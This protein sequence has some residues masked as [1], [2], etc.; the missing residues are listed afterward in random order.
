MHG[1]IDAAIIQFFGLPLM[2][3]L[4]NLWLGFGT[5]T[6][7]LVLSCVA[8]LMRVQSIEMRVG[9]LAEVAR[10]RAAVAEK[11][12]THVLGYSLAFRVY[13]Q[14]KDPE[15]RDEATREATVVDDCARQYGSFARTDREREMAT[16]IAAMWQELRATGRPL[17]ETGYMSLEEVQ[18]CYD[19]RTALVEFLDGEIQVD[20]L[21]TYN[22]RREA[23]LR[24]VNSIQ[25]LLWLL[26]VLGGGIT[27]ASSLAF[28]RAILRSEAAARADREL[29]RVTLASIG[30]AVITTDTEGRAAYLNG[31]AEDLTGWTQ[32][33]AA[34]QPLEQVF[35]IVD[36]STRKPAE[37]PAARAL[38]EGA[39]VGL[40][41]H[42]VLIA[43]DGVERAIDDSAAPIRDERG[44]VS[45]VVLVFRD[46]AQRRRAELLIQEAVEQFSRLLEKL[47]VA[48][49]T[50]D[51]DGLITYFN[52]SA[53]D[54]WGREP[55]LNDP[56]DRFC[57]S[58]PLFGADGEPLRH[59]ESWTALAL[60]EGQEQSGSEIVIER[61]D[62]SRKVTVAHAAPIHDASGALSGA[63]NVLVDITERKRLD[64]ELRRYAAEL[65]ENDRRKSEFLAMLAH[66]LRNP[67]APITN[68]LQIVRLSGPDGRAL[69][70]A[71]KMMERQ[72][73]QMVRLVDDLLDVS[74]IS[75]GMIV[76][77]KGRVELASIVRH[78]AEAAQSLVRELELE[79]TV[80]LPDPPIYLN[81][82]PTRLNQVI[83]NL[84]NNACKFSD[85][86]S[87][88]RLRVERDGDQ[89]VIRVEDEGIGIG[90]DQLT[91][92]FD[93]FMQVDTS[94]ERSFGG[95]G[96]GLTL[97]KRLVEM[98]GGTVDAHSEGAGQG[99]QFVVRLPIDA[100][101][102]AAAAPAP[103]PSSQRPPTQTT[104]ATRWRILVVD[105]N[106]DS[107]DSLARLLTITGHEAHTA[108]DGLEAVTAAAKL[109]PDIVL[110]DIGL[111]GLNGYEAGRR[112]RQQPWASRLFLVA[113]TGW[114]QE[115]DRVRSTEAGFDAH[116]V[117]PLELEALERL[118]AGWPRPERAIHLDED[119]SDASLPN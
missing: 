27:V 80:V 116:L 96:I 61:P 97:V 82:D 119:R 100:E 12:E 83:G 29:L 18:R 49:Y 40:S 60:R 109:E 25:A 88:V 8:M 64:D 52:R 33:E 11:L 32:A 51:A 53:T 42:T 70:S 107:A 30:D 26:L 15:T 69:A 17:L 118:L 87:R 110:M 39:V 114:G 115:R 59:D 99:S 79:M 65:S 34:G 44:V 24:D 102:A 41:N 67:L 6:A 75:R 46:I 117:K 81:A 103:S 4:R 3:T 74:R 77:R 38:R 91:N 104:Q 9:E 56:A 86:G 73:G 101:A 50:C 63:V 14:T 112:I 108:Y 90:P 21:E 7:L 54:L 22:A 57:K 98:H 58:F 68:A 47:P 28:G 84:L 78:A 35:R 55:K 10:A 76:L 62:G 111:P 36:E 13:F 16:R 66:E 45:G 93:T 20:A 37:S 23:A 113:L 31:A 43:R 48:A 5:L 71:S 94:L 106:R 92:I 105:D 95:L 72:V 1:G 19:L 85:R 2:A 89:A